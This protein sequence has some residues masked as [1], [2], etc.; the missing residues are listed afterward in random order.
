MYLAGRLVKAAG[1]ARNQTMIELLYTTGC[2]IADASDGDTYQY[3]E[4]LM[5]VY[6]R[7]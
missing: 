6:I 3:S 2:R 1:T 5:T 4:L 7:K